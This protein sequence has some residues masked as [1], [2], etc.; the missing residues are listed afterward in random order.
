ME[1]NEVSRGR[2]KEGCALLMS[3]RMWKGL[4]DCGWKGT[5]IVWAKTKVGIV[6]YA[7]I[8]IYALV[9]VKSGKGREEMREFGDE[10]NDCLGM[11]EKGRRM[12]VLGDMN[13][14]VGN[15]ELVGV[16]GK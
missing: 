10:I 1:W 14:R 8:C 4:E 15:S 7:W 12:V 5:R 13:G 6:K 16:V 11:F 9:N 3:E 2:G